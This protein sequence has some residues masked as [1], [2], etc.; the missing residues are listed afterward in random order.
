MSEKYEI[1]TETLID[2]MAKI[3]QERWADFCSELHG[4]MLHHEAVVE[5]MKVLSDIG[6]CEF[7]EPKT[8][9]WV[10][11]SEDT[12]TVNILEKNS[13]AEAT[14]IKGKSK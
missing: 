8:M 12:I 11:D 13:G 4:Y 3:P 1:S 2:A 7:E 5:G 10:D 9:T 6:L 14:I